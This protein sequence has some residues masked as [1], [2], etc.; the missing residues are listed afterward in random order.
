MPGVI[1]APVSFEYCGTSGS[2]NS[3][4]DFG[5]WIGQ[6]LQNRDQLPTVRQ[7]EIKELVKE[8]KD[9]AKII[10]TL[11][12][13]MQKRTHYVGIQLGIGGFQPFPAET[14]DQLGYGDCKA[15]TNYMRAL[16]KVS[17]I[18]SNYTVAGASSSRGITMTDF[19]TANQCN[20]VILCVPLKKDTIWLEC[21]SQTNPCGYMSRF[22]AGRRALVI[23]PMGNRIATIPMLSTEQNSQ[24][25]KAEV[26][27]SSDGGLA[28]KVKTD[29]FGYQYDN[30]SKVL[31]ESKKE[32]EK[33][34]YENLAVAGMQII[35]FTYQ[36][37]KERLPNAT[38]SIALSS[39]TFTTRSGSRIFVP[40]NIFNQIKSIPARVD[41][42]KMPVYREFGFLDTDSVVFQLP[43]GYKPESVPRGKTLKTQFGEYCSTLT[44]KEDKVLYTRLFKMNPGTWPKEDYAALVDFYTAVVGADKVKLV[45]REEPRF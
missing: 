25:R 17:G 19:P 26:S 22:T 33:A 13:Y 42:R 44:V 21:T 31:T 35:D 41:N 23:D 24:R 27:L 6:L 40:V 34:L 4:N 18:K 9:T 14:V 32:Q 28:A 20:H 37:N 11:Y 16:L 29:Y 5:Q 10:R 7:N 8:I 3:W 1:T 39:Q 45:I 12:E 2:M 15:L 30:V 38:E 43:K 36:E